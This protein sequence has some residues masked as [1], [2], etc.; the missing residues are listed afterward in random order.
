MDLKRAVFLDLASV[1]RN[2]L[3]LSALESTVSEWS[4]L[5]KAE[6]VELPRILS[7]VD[8]VV[9]NKVMLDS[10]ALKNAEHLKLICVAATGTNNID[11]AAAKSKKISVCNVRGY[12]T[13]SVVQHVFSMLLALTTQLEAYQAAVRQGRWCNSEHFC[14]LDYP[15]RELQGKTLG[16]VGYGELGQAVAVAA[17]VFGMKVLV[18]KRDEADTREGRL[19]LNEVIK[20]SD[21]LSLHCPLNDQTRGL[22]GKNELAMMKQDAILINT[23]R[24]GLVDEN[25][26]YQSLKKNQIGGAAI[27]VLEHEPPRCDHTL[28]TEVMSNLVVTPHTA[29][30]SIESRQ[31]LIDE[32]AKNIEAFKAGQARNLVSD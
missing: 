27:D 16:I 9:S 7:G 18:A 10:G 2:D 15:V 1:Y 14:L 8:V 29:W 12:A 26:L 32:L 25:A 22:I 24:G 6:A 28:L 13:A 17:K 4:W 5:D 3:D 20:Q 30:A 21:V 23:A 11:I 19:A 31:R